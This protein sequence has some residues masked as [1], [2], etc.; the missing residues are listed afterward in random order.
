MYARLSGKTHN[1]SNHVNGEIVLAKPHEEMRK[2]D[3]QVQDTW[4]GEDADKELKLIRKGM[5][6][7]VSLGCSLYFPNQ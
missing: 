7:V 3:D 4:L 5:I 6:T 2:T 1:W